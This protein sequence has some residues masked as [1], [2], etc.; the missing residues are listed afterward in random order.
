M[1]S[2]IVFISC[3]GGLGREDLQGNVFSFDEG[4]LSKPNGRVGSVAKFI[5][6]NVF[7]IVKFV[8]NMGR[9]VT[10]GTVAICFLDIVWRLE[11]GPSVSR[12][13]MRNDFPS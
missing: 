3:L 7:G 5:E 8:S 13:M 10:S 4:V 11:P 6:D 9:M 12:S 2:D 1:S